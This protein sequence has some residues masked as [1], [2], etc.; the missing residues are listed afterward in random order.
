MHKTNNIGNLKL[1]H[2]GY[3]DAAGNKIEGKVIW[4]T[5]V[6]AGLATGEFG[7]SSMDLLPTDTAVEKY[8]NLM[9]K[10]QH[11]NNN[12]WFILPVLATGFQLLSAWLS[13]QPV[14]EAE[15]RCRSAAA[16]HEFHAVAVP[17]NE[18]LCMLELHLGI[19]AL[20][21]SQQRAS[22]YHVPAHEPYHEQKGKCG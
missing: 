3:T 1:F 2:T 17:D 11:G 12:G 22:D 16:K 19:L 6:E 15:S 5:L 13:M 18:L 4:E 8:D 14:Q 21:G 20:L 10:Y 7:S 9:K